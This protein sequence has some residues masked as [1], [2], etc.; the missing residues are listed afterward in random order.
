M[1]SAFG[2]QQ[3]P[4]MTSIT[5]VGEGWHQL[6]RELE[7]GLNAIDP[8]FELLQVK[9]KFGGLRYYAQTHLVNDSAQ[10]R[11]HELIN[12]AESKSVTVCEQCGEPGD[13]RAGTFG[14]LKTLC[15]DHQAERME[16]DRKMKEELSDS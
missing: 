9:E 13:V 16:Q 4:M 8:D 12:K 2:D 15:D 11:F 10:L 1:T 7:E 6:I 3:V 14:W 5:N